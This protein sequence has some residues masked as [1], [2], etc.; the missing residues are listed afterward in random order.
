DD[1]RADVI[2]NPKTGRQLS[3]KG[4]PALTNIKQIKI[5]IK[6]ERGEDISGEIWINEIHLEGSMIRR[7]WAR[8]LS[9]GLELPGWTKFSGSWKMVDANFENLSGRTSASDFESWA[10]NGSFT[11]IKILPLSGSFS[12]SR[13]KASPLAVRE[14]I[15]M[16]R[17]EGG[18]TVSESHS[19]SASLK[20]GKLP[21]FTGNYKRGENN[22]RPDHPFNRQWKD[23]TSREYS[24]RS[25]YSLPFSFPHRKFNLF[26]CS[27]NGSYKTIDNYRKYARY[28][29]TLDF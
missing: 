25:G 6:N 28:Y 5:G 23:E 1:K 27:V 13:T 29:G 24:G 16:K 2:I 22:Y 19:G 10:G 7:G 11:K 9:A 20:L 3:G 26:P 8:R 17:V 21:S 4:K 12:K 18:L 15:Q 14:G